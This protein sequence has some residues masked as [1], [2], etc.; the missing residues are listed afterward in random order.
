[1]TWIIGALAFVAIGI[2]FALAIL[3]PNRLS[4][5]TYLDELDE[6]ERDYLARKNY[7]HTAN[8][9]ADDLRRAA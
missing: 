2:P 4:A 5:R 3:L 1:M 8:A 9:L 7:D 6:A